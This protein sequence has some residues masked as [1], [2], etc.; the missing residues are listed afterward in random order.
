MLGGCV[1]HMSQFLLSAVASSPQRPVADGR[2]WPVGVL[3]ALLVSA[4]VLPSLLFSATLLGRIAS[5]ERTRLASEAQVVTLRTA[6]A[7]DRELT[8]QQATLR[9]L[10]SSPALD[11]GDLRAFYD[12]A[13]EV[14]NAADCN[15][16]LSDLS[17]QMLLNTCVPFGAPL[18]RVGDIA[19]YARAVRERGI[20][21]S[22][23]FTGA[24]DGEATLAV[25]LPVM[26]GPD[27]AYVLS[28]NLT[29]SRLSKILV[30]QGLPTDWSLSA[31]DGRSAVIARSY[32]AE[33]PVGQLAAADLRSH[34]AGERG[35]WT[36]TTV[37]GTEVF[38]T[39][40][41]LR[42]AEWRVTVGVPVTAL[43]APMR[44]ALRAL[45]VAGMAVLTLSFVMAWLLSSQI[46]RPLRALALTGVQLGRGEPVDRVRS[47]VKEVD[48]VARALHVASARLTSRTEA[49]A[50]ERARL[51]AVFEAA[52]VGIVI[53]E[54]P[55]GHIVAGNAQAERILRTSIRSGASMAA[56]DG[57]RA[58]HADGT[59]VARADYPLL[60]ALNG[61]ERPGLECRFTRDDGS[62]VWVQAIAAPILDPQGSITG[63]VV[64]VL[65][66]E[67]VVQARE[68]S[69]RFA[70]ELERLVAERTARLEQ[71]LALL[72]EEMAARALI[73]EQLRQAHKM[74]SV[75]RLTGGIAHD[76]NNLLTIVVGSL[77]LLRRR[78][79]EPRAVRL[80][81]S[82]MDG[83]TRGATLTS[84]LLAF[85]RRQP[86]APQ[87]L[88]A[89][90]LIA[91]MTELLSR[92]LGHT[93]RLR[94]QLDPELHLVHADHSQLENAML[95][96]AVNAR[97]AM[98]GTR[99]TL[100]IRTANVVLDGEA[101]ELA[102]VPPGD[103]VQIEVD[104]TGVGMPPEVKERA[105]EPFF[106][107]KGVGQGTGLGLSQ[108]HGFVKQS[109]GHVAIEAVVEPG[110]SR[111]TTVRILLPS[112]DPAA[113]TEAEA[114]PLPGDIPIARSG[115]TV[116]VVEDEA[117]VRRFS[118]EALRELGYE[119]LEVSDA[120]AAL[121][122]LDAHPE[123]ALLFTDVVLPS[124]DGH[125]LAQEARRRR[126]ELRVLFTSGQGRDS[127]VREEPA[128]CSPDML[129]KPFTL[130]ALAV[131]V[132]ET[133]D[134]PRPAASPPP[135]GAKAS[136]GA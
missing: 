38:V 90:E 9:A 94:T 127:L 5:S 63:A 28:V 73:E 133:L 76:F 80:V 41:R 91:G 65:D 26:R 46:I 67:E 85:S 106:T 69:A 17:G 128:E 55:S 49:L 64:A 71:A 33:G 40:A 118:G 30:S 79:N 86:L 107:T 35:T 130:A 48:D 50:A 62:Q 111:G 12:Q 6:E 122:A 115:E 96:L 68:R 37:E 77:E 88:D 114:A 53:A 104:D 19:P 100:T 83:A 11:S 52:P 4:L 119:V 32:R 44:R 24:V 20:V 10:A 23:M 81:D 34:A 58:V 116:L 51:S 78:V 72:Q 42:L 54:A 21:V 75:G 84:R 117:G 99:G 60:R 15:V 132:R 8:A 121:A 16:V 113:E 134:Q 27:V 108:V 66:V 95:N 29:P 13:R 61:E 93:V 7:L 82:A 39:Y 43:E 102:E 131:R 136:L 74:E 14:V 3:V 101:A 1:S 18:P 120:E 22:N 87:A 25:A 56:F 135:A 97:D 103:Y 125:S 59:P 92:T 109:G 2:R 45:S 124:A 57:R 129:A 123:I 110:P 31:V 112:H 98:G 47:R 70:E 89:N 126:P 105:F 36:G